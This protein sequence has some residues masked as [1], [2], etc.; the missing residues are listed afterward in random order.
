[1]ATSSEKAKK[2]IHQFNNIKPFNEILEE[3]KPE[4]EILDE[5]LLPGTTSWNEISLNN[6]RNFIEERSGMKLNYLRKD[7]EFSNP[8]HFR[9]N[10]ENYIGMTCVPTGIVGPLRINGTSA[11]GDFIVPM[12]TTEGALIASYH[13]GA[14]ATRLC[15]GITSVCL[16]EGVQRTPIFKFNSLCE[17]GKFLQ[18]II[19][20]INRFKKIVTENSKHAILEEVK[21][22][23][24]G[25]QV[26]LVFEYTTGDASGQNMVT[27]CTEAVCN[28]IILNSPEKPVSWFIESNYSGDKKA[29]AVS[30]SNVRGKKVTAEA[31]V[32]RE[33][34][35]KI[36]NAEPEEIYRYWI[37]STVSTIQSGSLGNQGH[38]A[39]GLA[40]IF[41]ACGQ[42][43][44]CVAESFAGITR[45]EVTA[46]N[47]LYIAVTLPCL[48]DGTV[49]GGTELPTQKECLEILDCYGSGKARKFA[50]ICGA[51][52][53]AGELS[54]AAA[55]ASGDFSKAHRIF[56][57][58]RK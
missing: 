42:D 12:A 1:M 27:F 35:K 20:N 30:F 53:L 56:G 22:N 10:I 54:I 14:K 21:I 45:M 51:A 46:N 5:V 8:E 44:A 23:M 2:L 40:A 24:E 9:G 39:N 6:R 13:R 31:I 18:W 52:V 41:M 7:A 38:F 50:E 57:R 49:G 48:M 3:L 32:K 26:M 33:I 43:V 11:H 28:Y 25:N 47:D 29:T 58:K 17:V 55:I 15:G 37:S 19:E 36:L 34:A 16:T 4:N